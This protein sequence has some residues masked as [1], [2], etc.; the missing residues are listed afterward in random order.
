MAYRAG[1][2]HLGAGYDRVYYGADTHC[3]GLLLGCSAAFW[4]ASRQGR[5]VGRTAAALLRAA[6]AVG[7]AALGA[8]ALAGNQADA[9]ADISIA[10]VATTMI[11]A[12]IAASQ[13][14][15]AMERLLCSRTA[16]QLGRRSYGLYLWQYLLL[17]AAEAVVVPATGYYPGGAAG[18]FLFALALTTGLAATFAAA[19]LSYRYVEAPALAAQR[20][21]RWPASGEPAPPGGHLTRRLPRRPRAGS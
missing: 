1:L 15:R 9:A 19:L 8:L 10:A 2:A 5:P 13:L 3:D 17:A 7:A 21:F 4:L 14:P 11:V 18:R 12:A 16:V 6:A 20:R